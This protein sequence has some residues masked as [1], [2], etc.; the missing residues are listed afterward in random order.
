MKTKL[1]FE[2][3]GADLPDRYCH[4]VDSLEHLPRV[5][6]IMR[7]GDIFGTVANSYIHLKRNGCQIAHITLCEADDD[8]DY[9]ASIVRELENC[10]WELYIYQILKSPRGSVF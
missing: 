7:I 8:P 5:G 4:E 1:T 6:D 9:R 3:K 2:L 10:G